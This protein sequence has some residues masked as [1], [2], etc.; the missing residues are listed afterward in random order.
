MKKGGTFL[1]IANDFWEFEDWEDESQKGSSRVAEKRVGE[2]DA[3]VEARKF[4]KYEEAQT[5]LHA[6]H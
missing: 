6:G 5:T 1:L 4:L 2:G 3:T